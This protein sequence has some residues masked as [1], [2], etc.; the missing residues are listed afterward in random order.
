[1]THSPDLSRATDFVWRTARLIDRRRFEFL[2]L[3]AEHQ[4][5]LEALRPYQN[6]DGGFGNTLE[7][8]I[9]APV[10]QP[11]PTWTALCILD[12]LAAF[13][14]PMV[15]R[16]CDY[17]LRI[18]TPEG[19]VPFAL[20]TVRDYPR[21]PWWE[22]DDQPP[23]SLNPT[24]AIAALL[25]KHH[26]AHPWLAGA[27]DYCWRTLDSMSETSPYELRAILP[28]LE[29]APDRPR[30]EQI[31]ARLGAKALEQ[32]LIALAPSTEE[33]T[34]SPLLFAPSPRSI[35]RPLFSEQV[36]EAHLDALA[37]AQK[38]DGGWMFNWLDWNTATTL[39][40]RGIVTIEALTILRAYGRL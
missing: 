14:D 17:L 28:F 23:A 11:I 4:P 10:S 9:R 35:A 20:P 24:A 38:D 30:A 32:K 29:H 13:D 3:G 27:T 15:A 19:G 22:A 25:Y 1:M 40:W 21:A 31:F 2:F 26:I 33:D 39:E 18:T 5:A 16:A 37:S 6:P 34:H 12:E 7:P 8:D 36:I